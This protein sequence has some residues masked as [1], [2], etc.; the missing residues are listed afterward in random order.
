[1]GQFY[2]SHSPPPT[3]LLSHRPPNVGLVGEALSVRA[4]H[5]VTLTVPVRG[6]KHDVVRHAAANARD[7]LARRLAESTT[8]RQLLEGLAACL[9]LEGTPRRIEVFDNSHIGGT[10]A[11]GAMIVAGPDGFMKSAYRKFNIRGDAPAASEA[12]AMAPA[13]TT[14]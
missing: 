14:R 5:K 9:D 11:V 10:Q 12:E 6:E 8:Q 1:L 13:T 3:L 4:G 2:A 7:A